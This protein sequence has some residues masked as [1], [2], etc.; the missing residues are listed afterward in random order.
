MDLNLIKHA[1]QATDKAAAWADVDT[2]N[3]GPVT[4]EM[5]TRRALVRQRS[6]P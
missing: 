2:F 6:T 3:V 5:R 1:L 4:V